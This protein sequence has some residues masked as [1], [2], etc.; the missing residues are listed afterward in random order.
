M[1]AGEHSNTLVAFVSDDHTSVAIHAG[2]MIGCSELRVEQARGMVLRC[3][4]VSTSRVVDLERLKNP[5][6]GS[7][8][9]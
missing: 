1:V 2:F 9:R 5:A 6:D 3:D 8:L 4:E 7:A